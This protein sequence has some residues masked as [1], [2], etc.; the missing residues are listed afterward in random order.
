MLN[1]RYKTHKTC[2][3]PTDNVEFLKQITSVFLHSKCWSKHDCHSPFDI[4]GYLCK[5]NVTVIVYQLIVY[6]FDFSVYSLFFFYICVS[7]V[8]TKQNVF[9]FNFFVHDMITFSHLIV[10]LLFEIICI[11]ANFPSTWDST[12]VSVWS[13]I[14][15]QFMAQV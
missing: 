6:H 15:L 7:V 11:F 2:S 3:V 5:K 13:F 8:F 9:S 4:E 14:F 10:T 12:W 1:R